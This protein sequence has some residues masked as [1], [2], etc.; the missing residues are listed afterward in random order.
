MIGGFQMLVHKYFHAGPDVASFHITEAKWFFITAIIGARFIG[1]GLAGK[2]F[3]RRMH[4]GPPLRHGRP[5]N[6]KG[7]NAAD[8]R[9]MT[10]PGT[11]A[12]EDASPVNE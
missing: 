8:G 10:R 12:D 2:D 4:G 7:G 1:T 5:I 11:I 3:C 9:E 6:S